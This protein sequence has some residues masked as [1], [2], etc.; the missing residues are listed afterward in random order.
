MILFR[1]RSGFHVVLSGVLAKGLLCHHSPGSSSCLIAV[2]LSSAVISGHSC[3][4]ACRFAFAVAFILSAFI[5]YFSFS[6]L[7]AQFF[8]AVFLF[9]CLEFN[10]RLFSFLLELCCVFLWEL[11]FSFPSQ[12][13]ELSALL[14]WVC[15]SISFFPRCDWVFFSCVCSFSFLCLRCHKLH[16]QRHKIICSL[17]WGRAYAQACF[18]ALLAVCNADFACLSHLIF[19]ISGLSLMLV[20]FTVSLFLRMLSAISSTFPLRLAFG[21]SDSFFWF[22]S[23]LCS[24]PCETVFLVTQISSQLVSFI[25]WISVSVSFLFS[26][27]SLL[28]FVG[29]LAVILGHISSSCFF[30]NFQVVHFGGAL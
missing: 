30:G 27:M 8:F 16:R 12:S 6:Q 3:S 17:Q 20:S 26:M 13:V 4:D 19:G 5:F 29:L 23:L 11:F 15:F 28:L 18:P 10:I 25:L 24:F 9:S 1:L 21:W 14:F 22:S 7:L 2:A